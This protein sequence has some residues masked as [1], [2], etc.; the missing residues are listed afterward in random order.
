MPMVGEISVVL[1]G[2]S[3]SA[4]AIVT[5]SVEVKRF[6]EVDAA[7]AWK[8]ARGTSRWKGGASRR[9][10]LQARRQLCAG[11]AGGL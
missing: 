4:C 5:T 2:R 6:A 11:D 7:F 9:K 1:D 3:Q 10:L 8:E